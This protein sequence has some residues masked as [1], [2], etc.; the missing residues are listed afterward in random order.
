M[1]QENNAGP[2][3]GCCGCVVFLAGLYLIYFF[4][5]AILKGPETIGS[6]VGFVVLI[7]ALALTGG[8]NG[9]K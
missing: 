7:G 1:S 2:G 4:I 6:I 5:T 9:R 3:A 8:F